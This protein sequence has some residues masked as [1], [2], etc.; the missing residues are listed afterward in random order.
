MMR[1]WVVN[2]GV[3]PWV[4]TANMV[5]LLVT[6]IAMDTTRNRKAITAA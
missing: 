4:L 2:M 6:A 5:A 3:A 1:F